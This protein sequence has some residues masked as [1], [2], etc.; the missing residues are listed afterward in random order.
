MHGSTDRNMAIAH[1]IY[2]D[3]RLVVSTWSGA[4]N[5]DVILP[6]Y[7]ALYQNPLWQPGFDEIVDMR[8]VDVRKVT[9]AG[10]RNFINALGQYYTH[11][12]RT[13]I[14]APA[15]LPYG[16]A[17]VYQVFSAESPEE[18]MVFRSITKAVNWLGLD[19]EGMNLDGDEDESAA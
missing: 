11:S 5:D 1:K 4:F 16:L 7:V 17:R 6:P 15:D 12:F 9:S 14:V 13:A 19:P 10:L 8:G 2:P 3:K 18:V